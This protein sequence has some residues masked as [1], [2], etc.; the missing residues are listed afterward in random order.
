MDNVNS[1]GNGETVVV[2]KSLELPSN[3]SKRQLKRVKKKEKWLERKV[4]KRLENTDMSSIFPVS[5]IEDFQMNLIYKRK[6]P[7]FTPVCPY[8]TIAS[9]KLA[10][11]CMFISADCERELKRGRNVLMHVRIT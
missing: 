6:S 8:F 5:S 1:A 4:E 3:L 9:L 2:N 11:N 10:P 7:R